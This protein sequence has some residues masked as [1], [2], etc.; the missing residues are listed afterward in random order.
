MAGQRSPGSKVTLRSDKASP[1]K[2]PPD[3]I[4]IDACSQ[5][6]VPCNDAL[7]ELTPAGCCDRAWV[8]TGWYGG[9]ECGR[10]G[11]SGQTGIA[12]TINT[13]R[14][15]T[16]PFVEGHRMVWCCRTVGIQR[17]NSHLQAV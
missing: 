11:A 5:R 8:G 10:C 17:V 15:L 2:H 1:K 6:V 4:D 7:C 14:S 13:L 12:A 3:A 9:K 16:G